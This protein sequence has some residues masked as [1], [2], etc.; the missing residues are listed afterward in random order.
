MDLIDWPALE[1]DVP[2][3][4]HV[5]YEQ[6]GYLAI[7]TKGYTR[8]P[9]FCNMSSVIRFKHVLSN[10][11]NIVCFFTHPQ[12]ITTKD[13]TALFKGMVECLGSLHSKNLALRTLSNHSFCQGEYGQLCMLSPCCEVICDPD[14]TQLLKNIRAIPGLLLFQRERMNHAFMTARDIKDLQRHPASWSFWNDL[15]LLST[16]MDL[17][18][19]TDL[20]ID[21][22]IR[23]RAQG[24]IDWAVSDV[25]SRDIGEA[26]NRSSLK[27]LIRYVCKRTA[28]FGKCDSDLRAFFGN[29]PEGVTGYFNR[30]ILDN[31]DLVFSVWMEIKRIRILSYFWSM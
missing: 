23:T 4:H 20:G 13:E 22:L 3:P 17:H 27:H 6:Q 14:G 1:E 11:E 8:L 16:L 28:H 24:R 21:H 7:A 18:K 25:I 19:N 29:T 2:I 9:W 26:Y 10:G 5:Q 31:G 15:A 12:P 30:E